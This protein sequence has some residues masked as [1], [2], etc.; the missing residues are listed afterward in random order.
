MP[1]GVDLDQ[2]RVHAKSIVAVSITAPSSTTVKVPE[3]TFVD[4]T[5]TPKPQS[6]VAR[7]PREFGPALRDYGLAELATAMD[8]LVIRGRHVHHGVHQARKAIRRTRAMLSLG[9]EDLGPGA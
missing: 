5:A 4:A 3:P 1:I 2:W 9:R 6:A 7:P 8:A